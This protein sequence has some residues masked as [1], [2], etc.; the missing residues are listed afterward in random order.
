MAALLGVSCQPSTPTAPS[1]PTV[2]NS[3][4]SHLS[5]IDKIIPTDQALFQLA[6]PTAIEQPDTVQRT[7]VKQHRRMRSLGRTR[8]VSGKLVL[9]SYTLERS[10]R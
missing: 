1:A 5:D 7:N 10:M 9:D 6:A 3:A 2:S 4:S 8:V